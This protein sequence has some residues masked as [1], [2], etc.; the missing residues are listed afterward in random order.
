MIFI[1]H[2]YTIEKYFLQL[3]MTYVYIYVYILCNTLKYTGILEFINNILTNG[4]VPSLYS[5]QEEILEI[6][7]CFKDKHI[8]TSHEITM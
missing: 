4:F 7:H 3:N 1:I 8:N 2:V 6:I 5:N